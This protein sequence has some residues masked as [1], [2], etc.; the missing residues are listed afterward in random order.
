MATNNI[1]VNLPVKNLGRTKAFFEALG[2]SF[3]PQFTDENA[4]CLVISDNIYAMLLMEPFFGTFTQKQ[5][6][7]AKANVETLIAL[8]CDSREEV[9]ELMAKAIAAGGKEP[10]A[11]QD[12]GVMYSRA[13]DDLDGHTWEL[14]WMDPSFV[15]SG[16]GAA[17]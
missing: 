12:Q 1:F 11:A 6:V 10:R 17:Q 2:Y 7:D 16:P 4:A 15:Q 9:D 14:V 5:I 13:F 3:N 8:S